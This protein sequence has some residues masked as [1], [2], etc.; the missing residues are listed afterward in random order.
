MLNTD[1]PTKPDL[2]PPS[3]PRPEAVQLRAR[4]SP[5]LIAL[6]VLLV[7]LGGIGA[8]LLY[9]MNADQ[10]AV[11]A[12]AVD[13]AR[14]DVVDRDDLMVLEVP[15]S[16]AVAAEGAESLESLV[17]QVA[18]TDLPQ[19]SFPL[20]RH[21]GEEPLPAGQTLVGL[22]LALGKLPA[23]DL[24]P[25]TTVRLVGLL[26]GADTA[27]DALVA[28]R[29]QLLDDGAS[30]ALDVQVADGEADTVARLSAADQVALV[31]TTEG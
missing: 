9:T 24:P 16:L 18:R 5:K 17:G 3:A 25:G 21:V 8:A 11:V 7:T 26:D 15:G 10:R 22:R 4:R 20:R 14:G 19:G 30:Y 23:S 29:P 12:M 2:T 6:G 27:V 31:V 13:V 28:T 1:R